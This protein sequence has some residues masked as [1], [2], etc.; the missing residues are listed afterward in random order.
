M[1]I[2]IV[3][4][5]GSER[6]LYLGKDIIEG[7]L[8][9]LQ[10]IPS[11][12]KRY[13]GTS[14]AVIDLSSALTTSGALSDIAT[15]RYPDE[16]PADIDCLSKVHAFVACGGE[17][18]YSSSLKRWLCEYVPDYDVVHIHSLFC[19]STTIAAKLAFRHGVPYIFTP[20]GMLY[21][22]SLNTK[23][24]LKKRMYLE[25][26]DRR[27]LERA[28]TV[29]FTCEHERSNLGLK[30]THDRTIVM[31]N[32]LDLDVPKGPAPNISG[33]F[34]RLDQKKIA[35]FLS[36]IHPKKGLDILLRA[37]QPLLKAGDFWVLVIAG[38]GDPH[39]VR[40]IKRLSE[41][42]GLAENVYFVGHVDGDQKTALLSASEFFVLPSYTENYGIAVV[43]AMQA[44]LPV[45][46]SKEV[47]IA[48]EILQSGA[49]FV[50]APDVRGLTDSIRVMMSDDALRA[51]M[52]E[53]ANAYARGRS[54]NGSLVRKYLLLCE[55]LVKKS[56]PKT[57]R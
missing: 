46:I 12:H 52:A 30:L 3:L 49:G 43:E 26:V 32:I 21:P 23:G 10:V 19:Y 8:K 36:R 50:C 14:R 25:F 44:G 35:L 48:D 17:Y 47:G 45:V 1:L 57:S 24:R 55:S 20:H 37:M 6:A 5:G 11:L 27:L 22:W 33:Y 9:I 56:D 38:D 53:K 51:R 54:D 34:P 13:G 40:S 15:T 39:Y 42:L 18:K 31:P 28:S 29:H 16:D 2:G 4:S 41:Q 7:A